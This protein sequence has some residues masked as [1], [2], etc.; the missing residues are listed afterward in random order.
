MKNPNI[1]N[2][3]KIFV[4]GLS[5]NTNQV[6]LKNYFEQF[7]PVQDCA[8]MVEKDTG[9]S[10]GFGFVIMKNTID[11]YKIFNKSAHKLDGKQIDWKKAVPKDKVKGNSRSG[12]NASVKHI[13]NNWMTQIPH[14]DA[15]NVNSQFIQGMGT[16]TISAP[17]KLRLSANSNQR[18]QL[19]S[20]WY[21]NDMPNL[22]WPF[23]STKMGESGQVIS[24]SK[25]IESNTD[26]NII[27][28]QNPPL[29]Y[30]VGSKIVKPTISQM[31]EFDEKQSYNSKKIFVGGLP[32]GLTECEFKLYFSQFGEIEDWVVMYDRNSGKPRG[33][34][35]VTYSDERSADLVMKH[36]MQHKLSGKWI[37][38]KRATPKMASISTVGSYH[39]HNAKI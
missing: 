30:S 33:F 27:V 23:G 17:M 1:E 7:G 31:E 8:L 29:R 25:W 6:K 22:A 2:C 18:V 26:P 39:D 19:T 37:E 11:L 4:G 20:N 21:F 35:F 3:N 38:W 15:S 34:G 32:H 24:T 13:Q 12:S 10:R 36:K 16:Q 5:W 9:R 28:S 14:S